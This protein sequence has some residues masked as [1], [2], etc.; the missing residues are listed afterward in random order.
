MCSQKFV[1]M[2]ETLFL[3]LQ[4]F[5]HNWVMP[6]KLLGYVC[7]TVDFA[8]LESREIG[9]AQDIGMQSKTKLFFKQAF[10]NSKLLFISM[11]CP[12]VSRN[13]FL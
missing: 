3:S 8:C 6:T 1:L 2:F 7:M 12:G 10:Y 13:D 11:S 9:F 5:I 4:N